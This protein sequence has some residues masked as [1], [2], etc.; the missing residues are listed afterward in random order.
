MEYPKVSILTPTYDRNRFLPLM[1]LN[2]RIINY[3]KSKLEQVIYDDHPTNPLFKNNEELQKY[4][5]LVQPIKINY[6]YNA[7]RHLSIGEKRNL[8]VKN[9]KNKILIN[10]DDDDIY[11]SD[12]IKT[13]VDTLKKNKLGLVGSPEMLF[14]FPESNYKITAI[15]CPATRQ[16]HEATMCFTKRHWGQMGGFGKN[17]KGEGSSM[18]DHNENNC[19]KTSIFD[20]MICVA[21]PNNTIEKDRF[22]DK[23]IFKADKNCLDL[24]IRILEEITGYS[25]FEELSES[26]SDSSS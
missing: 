10:M 3:D 5:E 21:H 6:I 20:C 23:E 1:I 18:I 2:L 22:K 11:F 13:S 14:I 26:D 4:K 15:K 24:H 17:S 16:I 9:A 8:L 19:C 25:K 12:Y 7:K